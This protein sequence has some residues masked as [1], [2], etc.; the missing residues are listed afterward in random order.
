MAEKRGAYKLSVR[1]IKFIALYIE[2][3]DMA[4][5]VKDAGFETTSPK[6]YA[7]KLLAK[8]KI[9]RELRVQ[10]DMLKN[11]CTASAEEIMRFYTD[12]MRGEVT[13]QFGIEASLADRM[14]AA[15][16]LAKR[17]IDMEAI[18]NKAETNALNV[19]LNF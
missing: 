18:A 4:Q 11:E 7:K 16:A 17:K 2:T 15:D 5:A 3:G 8:E 12:V 1:E 6:S 19:T 10:L 14:K 13:D 9:Q